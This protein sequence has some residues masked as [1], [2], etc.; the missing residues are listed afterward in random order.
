MTT[1]DQD[2][3]ESDRLDFV[4]RQIQWSYREAH[5]LKQEES[6]PKDDY[7]DLGRAARNDV[8]NYRVFDRLLLY[9]RRIESSMHKTMRELEKLQAARKAEQARAAKR[10]S[11]QESPPAQRH[12]GGLKKQS[13]SAPGRMG[14]TLSV[15]KD[16]GDKQPAEQPEN[17]AKQSQ[18]RDN[19]A[20]DTRPG[21]ASG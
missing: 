6:Y 20:G 14:A 13:Q 9:E 12:K 7:M 11:A 10:E 21:I 3:T 8:A 2:L 4:V 15:I 16:Y 5:G 18:F 19:P 17:K 1:F